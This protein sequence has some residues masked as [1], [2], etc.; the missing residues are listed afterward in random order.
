[1]G[2]VIWFR[3]HFCMHDVW[4]EWVQ[5]KLVGSLDMPLRHMAQTSLYSVTTTGGG[6]GIDMGLDSSR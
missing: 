6:E 3:N 2:H 4:N 1:M 5:H